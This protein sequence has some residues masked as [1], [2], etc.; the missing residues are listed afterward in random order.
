MSGKFQK[1]FKRCD[2]GTI[3]YDQQ[4]EC[5]GVA[6][7]LCIPEKLATELAKELLK[8]ESEYYE[9]LTPKEKVLELLPQ[10]HAKSICKTEK[11]LWFEAVEI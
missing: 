6:I 8:S 4:Y 9:L 7:S 11:V 5:L 1:L 3:I 2:V 10:E